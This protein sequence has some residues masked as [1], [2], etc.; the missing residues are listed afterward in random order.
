MFFQ[1]CSENRYRRAGNVL[2]LILIAVA[3]FAALSY[4]VIQ[5]TRSGGGSTQA[6][7]V[8]L[9]TAKLMN[10]F[11]AIGSEYHKD[12]IDATNGIRIGTGSAFGLCSGYTGCFWFDNPSTPYT[13]TVRRQMYRLFA[14][15]TNQNRGV[16]GVSSSIAQDIVW[17]E[18]VPEDICEEVNRAMGVSGIP[19]NSADY[20][21]QPMNAGIKQLMACT[22]N[23]DGT[24]IYYFV[25]HS[26]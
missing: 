22:K 26:E 24:T 19:A 16:I 18:D 10:F 21:S 9:E 12:E 13:V 17:L 14:A 3:L 7:N 5:G 25:L 8:K 15:D 20:P 2:F 23:P 6:E 1:M 11:T 4:V